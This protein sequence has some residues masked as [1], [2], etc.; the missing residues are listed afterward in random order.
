MLKRLVSLVLVLFAFAVPAAL[1]D[2]AAPT[3]PAKK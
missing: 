3:A 1:A 2:D